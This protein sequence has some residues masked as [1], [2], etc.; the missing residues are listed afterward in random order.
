MTNP[1]TFI[2]AIVDLMQA[3]T[4]VTSIVPSTE[5]KAYH[6]IYTADG[7]RDLQE[8]IRNMAPPA[9]VVVWER[10]GQAISTADRFTHQ[11]AVIAVI[12]GESEG[13]DFITAF[14]DMTITGGQPFY[15]T[16]NRV[17]SAI[18]RISAPE[19]ERRSAPR[20]GNSFIDY[21]YASIQ[22]SERC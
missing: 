3:T 9:A 19:F 18:S 4:A 16:P 13:L 10:T 5:I 17:H 12:E 14:H 22:I 20:D 21:F 1:K 7:D 2:D 8:F 15:F 6:E 11:I